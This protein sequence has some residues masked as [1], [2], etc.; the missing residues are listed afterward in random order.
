MKLNEVITAKLDGINK[1]RDENQ[2]ILY[3]TKRGETTKTNPY[4]IEVIVVDGI[5]VKKGTNDN[6]I[7]QNGYVLSGNSKMCRFLMEKI[8]IGTKV[9]INDSKT[10]ATF[11]I[12]K[13][14]YI[15]DT[16]A[17]AE[18][19]IAHIAENSN[20][21]NRVLAM[22]IIEQIENKLIQ[23]DKTDGEAEFTALLD[24]VK[25]LNE[26]AYIVGT[27]SPAVEARG[28]WH[29]PSE[30]TAED[31][32]NTVKYLA[33]TGFN[34]LLVEAFYNGYVIY[35]NSAFC[36]TRPN[37]AD[38][39]FDMLE[40]F[41]KAGKK[42]GVEIHAWVEDF[43]V[44]SPYEVPEG[45]KSGSPI[46]DKHPEWAAKLKNGSIYMTTEPKFVYINAAMDEVQDFISNVYNEMLER[47]EID[48]IQLDYIRYP[49]GTTIENTVGFDDYTLAEFKLQSGIDARD[50]TDFESDEWLQFTNFKT[51]HV[52]RFVNRIHNEVR[53]FEKRTGRRVYLSTAVF[54]DPDIALK[55]KCQ[56]WQFWMSNNWLDFISPM[57][58]YEDSD[59]VRKEVKNM[60]DRY[61][62]IPN[63][64]G[65]APMYHHMPSIDSTRQ[66]V[67]T[68]DAGAKGVVFFATNAL[69]GE[70]AELLKAGP[71]KYKSDVRG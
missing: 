34:M 29:R 47:Y 12:D 59:E 5:V 28:I 38:K 32:E 39:D 62:N 58:Y 69:S 46:I 30:K 60:V 11:Y 43:F 70:Q 51:F 65:I 20:N 71:F 16:R 68:R 6:Q 8:L 63:Y 14:T 54:G 52:T 57:A 37:L 25:K 61:P 55:H 50:I 13:Q 67:A 18:L 53:E 9:E 56:N 7:P 4:G 26:K 15:T 1:F 22:E 31:I 24:E 45:T 36:E 21:D 48:G 3:T 2:L 40:E 64:A 17:T 44:G 23:L 42:Y 35:K 27:A 66:I 19:N 49:L 41:V 33:D 10:E